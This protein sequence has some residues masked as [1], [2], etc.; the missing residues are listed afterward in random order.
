MPQLVLLRYLAKRGNTKIAF[1]SLKCCIS[2]LPEFSQLHFFNLFDSRL[3]LTLL[4]DS[5]NLVIN[6]FSSGLLGAWLRRNE[7][8]GTAEVGLCSL[9]NVPVC[10]LLGFLFCKLMQ[11]H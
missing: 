1:F 10:C 4:H 5:L 2:A 11:K 7:V 8:E 3:I 6:A 9:H